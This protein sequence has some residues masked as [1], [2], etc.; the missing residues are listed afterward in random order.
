MKGGEQ[1]SSS[2][3]RYKS[4]ELGE[5]LRC[6]WPASGQARMALEGLV[7]RRLEKAFGDS[8]E[9]LV[10]SVKLYKSLGTGPLQKETV[11]GFMR[12]N[13]LVGEYVASFLVWIVDL[14]PV[15]FVEVFLED[16]VGDYRYYDRVFAK[17]YGSFRKTDRRLAGMTHR[18]GGLSKMAEDLMDFL[19]KYPG[20]R[21]YLMRNVMG[22]GE[23]ERLLFIT[24]YVKREDFEY[25]LNFLIDTSER[26][27]RYRTELQKYLHNGVSRGRSSRYQVFME[28]Y[29]VM[30]SSINEVSTGDGSEEVSRRMRRMF[31]EY[32]VEEFLKN[33]IGVIFV[34]NTMKYVV[35]HVEFEECG[36]IVHKALEVNESRDVNK[37]LWESLKENRRAFV[38]NIERF[39]DFEEP[40]LAK[41][42]LHGKGMGHGE[43]IPL[44]DLV[45]Y[46]EGIYKKEAMKYAMDK[47]S[48]GDIVS[49]V[50]EHGGGEADFLLECVYGKGLE[51]EFD[52]RVLEMEDSEWTD[53]ILDEMFKVLDE[54][55]YNGLVNKRPELVFDYCFRHS[56][57]RKRYFLEIDKKSCRIEEGISIHRILKHEAGTG[58]SV[59]S[60]DTYAEAVY[61]DGEE[62]NEIYAMSVS[63]NPSFMGDIVVFVY[64]LTLI[65]PDD[66]RYYVCEYFDRMCSEVEDRGKVW[67]GDSTGYVDVL[68]LND[69][70]SVG[71][72]P[73][74]QM[75]DTIFSVH[76]KDKYL[77]YTIMPSVLR[78]MAGGRQDLKL[79]ILRNMDS[80]V[81]TSSHVVGFIDVL[82]SLVHDSNIHICSESK[83]LLGCISVVSPELAC[84]KSQLVQSMLDR[85]YAKP[86]FSTIRA[87]MFNHYLCFNGLNLVVQ[88]LRM[89]IKEFRED[90]F[91]IL[92]SLGEIGLPK[93]L[94]CVFPVIFDSLSSF[95]IEN[96]FYTD[97]CCK[98]A[99]SLMRYGKDVSFDRLVSNVDGSLRV[100]RFLVHCLKMCPER[101]SEEVV[102]RIVG[103]PVDTVGDSLEDGLSE[104]AVSPLFLAYAPELAVFKRYVPVFKHFLKKLFVSSSGTD[105]EI[106]M[107]A[108]R[109]M[110]V[111]GF[112]LACCMTGQWRSRVL[113]IEL[114]D[115]KDVSDARMLAMVFILRNDPHSAVRQ[116]AT[117]VWR[118]RV[119]N[120]NTV[121]RE[122][123]RT[124]LGWLRYRHS[125][126]SFG[127]AMM[128]TLDEMV[129]K[130][131]RYVERYVDEAGERSSEQGREECI[132]TEAEELEELESTTEEEVMETILAGCARK[133]KYLGMVF[134]FA[135]SRLSID[136]LGLLARSDEYRDR[137]IDVISRE[138][139]NPKTSGIFSEDSRLA[140]ELFRK[141]GRTFLFRFMSESDRMG[142]LEC[143]V[144]R[145]ESD[146]K[147]VGELIR[148]MAASSRLEHV[149]LDTDPIYT[150]IFYSCQ[151]QA[152]DHGCLGRLFARAFE[153]LG[154]PELRPLI[155]ER[156]AGPLLDVSY[157]NISRPDEL[158]E[159]LCTSS[160]AKA[161]RRIGDVVSTMEIGDVFP[162]CGHLLRNYLEYGKREEVLPPLETIYERYGDRLGLFGVIFRRI[163]TGS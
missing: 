22:M 37:V 126:Q 62:G 10:S 13:E 31:R 133:N 161:F 16:G 35:K 92:N 64:L 104:L 91:P 95:V 156:Y 127:D 98:V 108:F 132:P 118:S 15:D 42:L 129:T 43:T 135:A 90:V 39:R 47:F 20:T 102:E 146:R 100:N 67:D 41:I 12:E 77:V 45:R 72:V 70:Q 93:D 66:A 79:A 1:D 123:Y 75:L 8:R 58:A 138:I 111:S 145:R 44:S 112:L 121:L 115:S 6:M 150:S 53:R 74:S 143:L 63:V 134:E 160:T 148:N 106:A 69:I 46:S 29:N 94:E 36:D 68:G 151:T 21:A 60:G 128:G 140:L 88:V 162:L 149:L 18:P 52:L 116:K 86:L 83:R 152:E 130:Y 89:Y 163:L 97:E 33:D 80:G 50:F 17:L 122:I 32:D 54:D 96:T 51:G 131:G 82:M 34:C 105:Q 147:T 56:S 27:E 114:F 3:T 120:A 65:R 11:G 109:T 9:K 61:S 107:K 141:T 85:M 40:D 55:I 78:M 23:E 137:A 73:L 81:V 38:E 155:T 14:L 113:C 24:R 28:M 76:L 84:F 4:M 2:T 142:L 99:S 124:V 30:K 49:M 136:L 110:D 19:A 57:L 7:V 153:T 144:G 139:N 25:Y 5:L 87:Q 59:G 101:R 157:K 71:G 117:E 159:V 125:S 26:P 158:I 119:S 48:V 154:Y 103:R